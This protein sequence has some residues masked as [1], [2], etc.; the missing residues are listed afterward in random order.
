M[1]T[2]MMQTWA[3]AVAVFDDATVP[4]T[5]IRHYLVVSVG[6]FVLSITSQPARPGQVNTANTTTRQQFLNCKKHHS[7]LELKH[8]P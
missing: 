7:A 6:K 8:N 1:D 3:A 4:H 2:E 5:Y